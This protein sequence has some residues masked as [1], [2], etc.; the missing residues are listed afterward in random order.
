MKHVLTTKEILELISKKENSIEEKL[1]KERFE[2][3]IREIALELQLELKKCHLDSLPEYVRLSSNRLYKYELNSK[4]D[5]RDDKK[6]F[7]TNIYKIECKD[8][9]SFHLMHRAGG[10]RIVS[11]HWTEE[12]IE[13]AAKMAGK[14][15]GQWSMIPCGEP[16]AFPAHLR[17]F[18]A[19]VFAKNGICLLD[20][21]PPKPEMIEAS[22]QKYE[23][24][25][26][27][28]AEQKSTLQLKDNLAKI[29]QNVEEPITEMETE[30]TQ[31]PSLITPFNTRP[32]FL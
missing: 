30:P 24:P 19:Q 14:L 29:K 7:F 10:T 15:G 16:G 31:A 22:R 3:K 27:P 13:E 12:S 25:K 18:A 6:Q 5:I 2:K 1:E 17:A 26:M 32:K 11:D 21:T 8:G 28:S 4:Q 9:S 23:Q 20:P